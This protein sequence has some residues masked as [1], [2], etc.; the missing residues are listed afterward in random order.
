MPKTD[1][2]CLDRLSPTENVDKRRGNKRMALLKNIWENEGYFLWTGR[3]RARQSHGQHNLSEKE[4]FRNWDNFRTLWAKL[5]LF[6]NAEIVISI[7]EVYYRAKRDK[8]EATCL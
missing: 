7:S 8:K 4:I 2:H 1:K 3:N 6:Y 5:Q